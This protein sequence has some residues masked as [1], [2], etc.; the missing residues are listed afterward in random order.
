MA[1]THSELIVLVLTCSLFTDLQKPRGFAKKVQ[2]NSLPLLGSLGYSN[3]LGKIIRYRVVLGQDVAKTMENVGMSA[4][5]RYFCCMQE[6][7]H[8]D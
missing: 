4:I 6:T 8:R 5:N 1:N 2:K 7:V 3:P